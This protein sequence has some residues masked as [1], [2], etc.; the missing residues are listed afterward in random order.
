MFY[1]KVGLIFCSSTLFFS[2]TALASCTTNENHPIESEKI[3]EELRIQ[4]IQQN[5]KLLDK[6][7]H[8]DEESAYFLNNVESVMN[9]DVNLYNMHWYTLCLNYIGE[10]LN[11]ETT[12]LIEYGL[13]ND[14]TVYHNKIYNN[15]IRASLKKNISGEITDPTQYINELKENL[16]QDGLFFWSS[17]SESL[18]DKITA[19][20]AALKTF[21]LFNEVPDLTRTKTAIRNLA[22]D[23]TLFTYNKN[24]IK[25]NLV[26][27]GLPLL[28]NAALLGLTDEILQRSRWLET[29]EQHFRDY[30]EGND[31]N[32]IAATQLVISFQELYQYI[33]KEYNI[34]QKFVDFLYP[35]H[36][37]LKNLRNIGKKDPQIF[38]NIL[39]VPEEFKVSTEEI[40]QLLESYLPLWQYKTPPSYNLEDLYYG[41]KAAEEL[42][43]DINKMKLK[44]TL[45]RN[46]SRAD[47]K[48]N[49][50]YY[51]LAIL[52]LLGS[53]KLENSH[54]LNQFKKILQQT[55]SPNIEEIYY[56]AY[57]SNL[58]NY[59]IPVQLEYLYD[60][61]SLLALVRNSNNDAAVYYL[62]KIHQIRNLNLSSKDITQIIERYNTG[63]GY[64]ISKESTQPNLISTYRIYTVKKLLDIPLQRQERSAILNLLSKL[65]IDNGG[66]KF[67]TEGDLLQSSTKSLFY[68]IFLF[69]ELSTERTG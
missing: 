62:A 55:S 1:R 35:A 66:F 15:F 16:G 29:W 9:K 14:Q 53:S 54:L 52:D 50:L 8:E 11:D 39:A 36:D 37:K 30:L 31:I 45:L 64:K 2:F 21:A 57:I 41:I 25:Y 51:V 23:N 17:E 60:P 6:L 19:T 32:I 7:Y 47:L 13:K 12:E 58:L 28:E 22:T 43:L 26:S 46:I 18:E 34:P 42:K 10:Q 5:T 3:I 49:E 63:S 69:N 20:N 4:T 56:I 24:E 67:E 33:G 61:E 44:S 59:E 40:G 65:R 38:Y 27:V 48:L 68:G